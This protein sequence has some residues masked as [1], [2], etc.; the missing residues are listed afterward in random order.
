LYCSQSLNSAYDAIKHRIQ[1]EGDEIERFEERLFQNVDKI[2]DFIV[3]NG[4]SR[5]GQQLIEHN[6]KS[7]VI[8]IYLYEDVTVQDTIKAIKETAI[9][10]DLNRK[11]NMIIKA[12]N[13]STLLTGER[14]RTSGGRCETH[15]RTVKD[16]D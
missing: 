9:Q 2:C 13:I 16:R 8:C 6:H 12:W 3:I 10:T 5:S 7:I 14:K 1:V 4:I 15:P 11:I